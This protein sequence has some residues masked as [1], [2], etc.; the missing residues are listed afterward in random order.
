MPIFEYK[1]NGCEEE[2]E[3]LVTSSTEEV[4]CPKCGSSNIDKLFSRFAGS[5]CKGCSSGAGGT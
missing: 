3:E 1:C 2:F 5:S 4:K